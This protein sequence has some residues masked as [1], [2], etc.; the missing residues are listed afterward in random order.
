MMR[1]DP[2][3]RQQ[4]SAVDADSESVDAFSTAMPPLTAVAGLRASTTFSR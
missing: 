2:R 3:A 1:V 4:I